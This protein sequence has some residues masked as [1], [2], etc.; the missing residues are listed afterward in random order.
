MI[1]FSQQ[2]LAELQGLVMNIHLFQEQVKTRMPD[3][4]ANILNVTFGY[5]L[6]GFSTRLSYLY[7]ADKLTGIGYSGVYPTTVLS[8]LHRSI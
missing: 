5:D 7:Q 2:L 8:T 1:V 3:Q 6:G 4:P